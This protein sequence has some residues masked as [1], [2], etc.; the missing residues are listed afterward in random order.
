MGGC[1]WFLTMFPALQERGAVERKFTGKDVKQ[2][3]IVAGALALACICNPYGTKIVTFSI[4]L[5]G[6]EY[7]KNRVWEWTSPFLPSNMSYYWLWLFVGCMVTL[8]VSIIIRLPTL[9]VIDFAVA[10]LVTYLGFRANRFVPDVAIFS[11]PIIVRSLKHVT[12]FALKP[13]R[14]IQRPWVEIGI[15]TL[16]LTNCV[17]YGYAHSAREHRPLPGYG[18]GGDMPYTETDLLRKL[19]IKGTIF[20]EYSDGALIINRLVPDIRPVLDSRIDLYPTDLVEEYDRAYQIPQ[21]FKAY[22]DKHKV[23]VV[24]LYRNRASP[25]V[26]Q[27]LD[28]SPEWERVLTTQGR[29]LW[30]KSGWRQRETA[31]LS[32]RHSAQEVKDD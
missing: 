22:T 25:A 21:L 31:G 32:L 11:F 24:L 12:D 3:A 6:N 5:L 14:L 18:F 19:K 28:S 29:Y 27:Y 16:L 1:V 17:V 9:P 15:A 4:D 8:W 23:N 26:V 7:A 13:E 20:N 10:V 2:L 30:L